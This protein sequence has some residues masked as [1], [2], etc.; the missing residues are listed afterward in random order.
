[1]EHVAKPQAF[2]F[3]QMAKTIKRFWPNETDRVKKNQHKHNII[4]NPIFRIQCQ[5]SQQTQTKSTLKNNSGNWINMNVNKYE[6]IE[7]FRV[8]AWIS[9][10][11][12]SN[13][14]RAP[15]ILIS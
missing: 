8:G 15:T 7:M 11:N 9:G 3:S 4:S 14:H 12:L 10:A 2:G 6:I 1:M 5:F 13:I